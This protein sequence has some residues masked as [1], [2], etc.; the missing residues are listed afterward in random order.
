MSKFIEVMDEYEKS[1]FVNTS[2]IQ[3]IVK[4]KGDGYAIIYFNDETIYS[5][6]TYE[7]LVIRIREMGL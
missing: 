6:E 7:N 5:K 3:Y 4:S 2:Q 1:H